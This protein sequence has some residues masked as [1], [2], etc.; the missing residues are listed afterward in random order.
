MVNF[1]DFLVKHAKFPFP[2]P[3]EN[4]TVGT[5]DIS[6]LEVGLLEKE[7]KAGYAVRD[8][9]LVQKLCDS[10]KNIL[11][12][13]ALLA[14]P[15]KAL[16]KNFS[17]KLESPAYTGRDEEWLENSKEAQVSLQKFPHNPG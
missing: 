13:T 7:W 4:R 6:H 15:K 17:P 16:L 11:G 9:D 10:L 1:H 14:N 2:S 3:D 5:T 8:D 12:D